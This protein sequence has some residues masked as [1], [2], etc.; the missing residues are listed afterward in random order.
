MINLLV[1]SLYSRLFTFF[2]YSVLLLGETTISMV[3]SEIQYRQV[4][5]TNYLNSGFIWIQLGSEIRIQYLETFEIQTFWRSDFKWSWFSYG[6]S[7]SPN[8]SKTGL[9]KIQ[10][11]L[12]GFQMAFDKMVAICPDF[13]WLGFWIPDP[14]WNPDYLQPRLVPFS[15]PTVCTLKCQLSFWSNWRHTFC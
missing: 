8:H 15:D 5:H 4:L 10:T 6:Y 2:Y 11:F 3:R 1:I 12:S 9:F 7:Y 13:K 14:I